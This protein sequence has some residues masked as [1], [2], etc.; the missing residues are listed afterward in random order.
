MS[1]TTIEHVLA[2]PRASFEKAGAFQ[3]FNQVTKTHLNEFFSGVAVFLP[4]PDAEQDISWKQL[5]PYCILTCNGKILSY[6]RGKTSGEKRLVSKKSIGVGGHINPVDSNGKNFDQT[7]YEATVK[8]ELFEELIISGSVTSKIRGLI[9]DDSN[10]VG[11]V[12]LGVIEVFVLENENVKPNEAA[13]RNIQFLTV[14]QLQA[15][16]DSL[17]PWS[18]IAL[19]NIK[20]I[21]GL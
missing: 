9:N 13:L 12:H 7:A 5:I 18:Q 21:L 16:R 1:N 17:E 8:R 15:E 19:D 3:G 14:E 11:S 20:E 10:S 6:E 4:R 2:I